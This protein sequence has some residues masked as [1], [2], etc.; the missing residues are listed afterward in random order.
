MPPLLRTILAVIVGFA[1]GSALNMGIILISPHVVP[2]P[3][4]VDVSK[5]ESIRASLHLYEPKHFLFPFLAHAGGTLAGAWV[6]CRLSASR[7]A[8]PAWIIGGIFL[9]GGITA[10]TMIPAPAWFIVLD[11]GAAYLPMAWLAA[12]LSPRPPPAPAS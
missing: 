6:A 8:R 5:V 7:S 1:A 12:R 2:P 4:G 11:L 9:L 3:P 10:A